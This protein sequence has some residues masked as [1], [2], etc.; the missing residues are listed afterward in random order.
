MALVFGQLNDVVAFT[1]VAAA[2]SDDDLDLDLDLGK[3]AT[4][5]SD[6]R[7]DRFMSCTWNT[8][9]PSLSSLRGR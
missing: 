6:K 7:V 3:V 9:R 8:S 4:P 5:L 2:D 1:G